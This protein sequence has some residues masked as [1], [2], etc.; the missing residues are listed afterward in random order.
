MYVFRIGLT[1][2][3]RPLILQKWAVP[4]LLAI[5]KNK[6]LRPIFVHFFSEKKSDENCAE[7]FSQQMSEKWNFPRKKFQKIVSP[8]I[9]RKIPRKVI[10]RGKM[11]KNRPL[12]TLPP[13]QPKKCFVLCQNQEYC[14]SSLSWRDK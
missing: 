13:R 14:H 11:Y 12:V 6:H 4:F 10:F 8:E 2:K 1:E 9:P 7:Y 3:C 5:F